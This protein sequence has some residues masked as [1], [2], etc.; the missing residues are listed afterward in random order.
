MKRLVCLVMVM[1]AVFSLSAQTVIGIATDK[2]TNLVFPF[3]V[4][5]VDRGTPMVLAQYLKETPTVL[6]V[7]A[8]DKNFEETNLSVVT[9][10]GSVYSFTIQYSPQPTHLVHYIPVSRNSTTASYAMGILDN[11]VTVKNIQ[12]S[13]GD[14]QFSL[15]GIYIKDDVIF[16][17][18][19]ID[20][21]SPIDYDVDLLRF[22]VKDKRIGKRT[23]VQE[24]PYTPLHI[25]GNASKVKAFANS[26]I[27]VALEK[28]T[29]PDKKLLFVQL[30]EKNGGRH[31]QLRICNQTLL[32]AIPLPDLR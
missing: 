8:A 17:Q 27:V 10:D 9:D 3:A 32:K 21:K 31:L 15:Q 2:T 13:S 22:Y 28:F 19:A 23:A 5:H 20:N 16:Y 26:T 14:V 6:L 25:A 12:A 18:L 24:I 7:K 4:K 30:A 29:I 11:P 1:L